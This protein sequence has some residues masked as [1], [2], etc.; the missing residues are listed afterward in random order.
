M[1]KAVVF[2]LLMLAVGFVF[3]NTIDKEFFNPA[4]E[5]KIAAD[6]E[7]LTWFFCS[8]CRKIFMAE[9]TTKKGYCAYCGSAMMLITEDNRGFSTSTNEDEFEWF[10]SPGCGK[11]FFARETREMGNCPYC[12]EPVDVTLT[13]ECPTEE[14]PLRVAMVKTHA[15]KILAVAIGLF[16]VSVSSIYLLLQKRVILTLEPV[17]G[18][19]SEEARIELSRR[20]TKKK[21]LT[22]GN[23]TD[24]DIL[25]KDA[26]LDDIHYLFSFVRVGGKTYAYLSR[27]KNKPIWIN[28]KPEYNPKLKDRDKIKIGD[29]VFEVHTRDS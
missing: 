16:V 1:K 12:G 26:S 21:R 4:E 18:A 13:P 25:L 27:G 10:F 2:G 24:D 15:G 3:W 29:I 22:L 7:D 17:E 5:I 9:E 8:D 19:P 20:Q 11:L 23:S 6:K 14:P 28:D